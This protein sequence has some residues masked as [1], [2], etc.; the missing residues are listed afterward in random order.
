[1]NVAIQIGN[2]DN[3]LSQV[4]WHR[5]CFAVSSAIE[6]LAEEVYFHGYSIPN[7]PLAKC[8]MDI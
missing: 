4:D 6:D 3:K 5:F 2:S 1:M 7:D 8:R